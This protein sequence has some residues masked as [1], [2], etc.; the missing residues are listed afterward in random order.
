MWQFVNA[1]IFVENIFN[2]FRS[3]PDFLILLDF[4]RQ[5]EVSRTVKVRL[6][7]T[8]ILKRNCF[9]PLPSTSHDSDNIE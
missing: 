4:T 2:P 7:I 8:E 6:F 1:N 3:V 9:P 5:G